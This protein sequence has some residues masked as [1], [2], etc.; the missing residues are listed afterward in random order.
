M[1]IRLIESELNT[2]FAGLTPG[3]RES[4]L[5]I[6]EH[7]NIIY[8]DKLNKLDIDVIRSLEGVNLTENISRDNNSGFG[9]SHEIA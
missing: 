3:N 4:T 6:D 8:L 1:T 7:D 2:G 5:P 9:N